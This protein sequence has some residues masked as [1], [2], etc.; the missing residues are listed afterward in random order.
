MSGWE[1]LVRRAGPPFSSKCLVVKENRW[2]KSSNVPWLKRRAWQS[3][4]EN[5][6][7]MQW[8]AAMRA[9][10]QTAARPQWAMNSGGGNKLAINANLHNAFPNTLSIKSQ[11]DILLTA[12]LHDLDRFLPPDYRI[13]KKKNLKT[14]FTPY[15]IEERGATRGCYWLNWLAEKSR[16]SKGARALLCRRRINQVLKGRSQGLQRILISHYLY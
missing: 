3:R 9:R 5:P 12:L 13:F 15:D 16:V 11:M 10:P 14:S 1:E 4:G 2:L 7:L 8:S 6:F